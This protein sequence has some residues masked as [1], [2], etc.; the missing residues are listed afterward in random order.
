MESIVCLEQVVESDGV[1]K[2][3]EGARSLPCKQSD[4]MRLCV[5]TIFLCEGLGLVFGLTW[6]RWC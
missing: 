6:L 2:E 1:G 5:V 4:K 3:E